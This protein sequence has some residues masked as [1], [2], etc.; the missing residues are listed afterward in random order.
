MGLLDFN[1]PDI[2]SP[3]GQGLLA[4]SLSLMQAKQMPGQSGA[5]GSALGQAGQQYM[6]TRQ[7]ATSQGTENEMQRLQLDSLKRKA[8]QEKSMRDMLSKFQTPA[9]PGASAIPGDATTGILPSAG[10]A[11][12][13]AGFDYQGYA[14]A[15]AGIDPAQSLSLLQSLKKEKPKFSTAPQYDQQGNAFVLADN[16]DVKRLDGV[17][18]RDKLQEVRL[19]D[20]VGFRTDY[21]PELQGSVPISQSPDSKA[22]NAIAMRGQDMTDSRARDFNAIAQQTNAIKR[23]EKADEK[24]LAKSGQVASFDVMLGSL[25]RLGK[26]PG[27]SRSVGVTGAFPTIPGSDSANFKAELDTFQSQAFLPMVSQLKGMGA[28][29]DAEGKKLTAAVGALNP[30][31]GEKAFRESVARITNDM[32][33]ARARLTGEN[34]GGVSGTWNDAPVSTASTGTTFDTKPPA[35]KFKGQT[36]TGPDGKRYKSDGMMWKE[37]Q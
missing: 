35:Q 27:L 19:G 23:G 2:N 28:L 31:M 9:Q 10:Q 13:P 34:K 32:T 22:G 20:K 26:H 6:K 4:A 5:F 1:L 24:N 33:A 18:A 14:D 29:S 7:Q 11:A 16:G 12:K 36:A 37:V 21:S 8:E 17:K 25:D 15:L 3:E 30:S